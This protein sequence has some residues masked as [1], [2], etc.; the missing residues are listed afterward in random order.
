MA[1]FKFNFFQDDKPSPEYE[2]LEEKC[3]FVANDLK[4][5][6]EEHYLDQS[7]E[8]TSLSP[9]NIQSMRIKETVIDYISID[10]M[11]R[12][13]TD[14]TAASKLIT[15]T[16]REDSDLIPGVYEG[17]FKI[18]EC[19]HDLL[20]YMS[21]NAA[22]FR[23]KCVLDLGCG[24]GLLGIYALL[25]QAKEVHFQDY[26]SEVIQFCTMPNFLLNAQ[27]RINNFY[28]QEELR[29]RCR[30]FSGKWSDFKPLDSKFE[31]MQY[32]II[33]TSETIYNPVSHSILL[34]VLYNHLNRD[35]FVLVAAKKH[36]FGVGGT[37]EMFINHV[38][39]EKVLS[40]R[41]VKETATPVP[42]TILEMKHYKNNN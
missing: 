32:D 10:G 27:R 24:A 18:W 34:K 13:D 16:D 22:N 25:K 33:L 15:F 30:F 17:G 12:E 1:T 42:R 19:T 7:S 26:N 6:F 3:G 39:R 29:H 8:A 21:S 14:S 37:L 31:L 38:T 9:P 11:R 4:H 36:Y 40:H 23:G 5:I 41:V 28:S 35:G 20:T 2:N